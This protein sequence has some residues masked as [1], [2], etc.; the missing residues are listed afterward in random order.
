VRLTGLPRGRF[1]VTITARTSTGKVIRGTR[2]YRTC[3]PKRISGRV[4]PL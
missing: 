4:P 3:T 1:T 2:R